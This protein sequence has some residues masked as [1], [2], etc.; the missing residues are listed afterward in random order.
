MC[1]VVV[2]ETFPLR[3]RAKQASLATAANW[4]GNCKSLRACILHAPLGT[5]RFL[6][7]GLMKF[8]FS[9]PS[10][11]PS[12]TP[13]SPTALVSSSW[14]P[15]SSPPCSSGYSSMSPP[16]SASRA[17]TSCTRTQKSRPGSHPS[18]RH[19]AGSTALSASTSRFYCPRALRRMAIGW[20]LGTLAR[21]QVQRRSM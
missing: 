1:W 14:R 3:T 4:G 17:S 13:V 11:P 20:I 5:A 12:P 10:S 19:Q 16:V 15:T 7:N 18:G 9:S 8:Q 6:N 21:C 2:A